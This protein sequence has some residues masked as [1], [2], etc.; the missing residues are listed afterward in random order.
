LVRSADPTALASALATAGMDTSPADGD[1][2]T[3]VTSDLRRIGEVAL[4][5]RI[6]VHELRSQG[7]DLEAL[8]F[9]LTESPEN[10]NRNLAGQPTAGQPVRTTEGDAS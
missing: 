8:F 4:E 9:E 3:V 10:A 7:A 1:A 6:A 5:A 2:I